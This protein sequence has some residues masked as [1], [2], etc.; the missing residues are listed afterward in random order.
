MMNENERVDRIFLRALRYSLVATRGGIMRARILKLL[1]VKPLNPLA[2]AKELA[3]DYK[4]ATHHLDKLQGQNLVLKK[5][6]G[7]GSVYVPTFTPA[8]RAAFEEIIRELGEG[9]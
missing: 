9:L 4:T 3:I 5:G 7:Y 2:L 6:D 1:L 8:Q